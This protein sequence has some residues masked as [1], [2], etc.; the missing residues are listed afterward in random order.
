MR[1]S[2]SK[3]QYVRQY[4]REIHIPLK[5]MI[6]PFLVSYLI[7]L[8]VFSGP[9]AICINMLIFNDYMYLISGI[10]GLLLSFVLTLGKILYLNY[11]FKDE[12]IEGIKWYYFYDGLISTISMVLVMVLLF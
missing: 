2:F 4:I 9:I 8:L 1:N 11:V 12:K 6:L 7:A 3:Y 10:M 5:Q